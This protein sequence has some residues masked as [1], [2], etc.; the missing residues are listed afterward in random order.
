MIWAI[1]IFLG[2]PLWIIAL[3]L[4]ALVRNRSK[5]T[6]IPGSVH[7]KLKCS[8]GSVP[9]LGGDYARYTS[10]AHWI[11]DVLLVHKGTFLVQTL[12]VGVTGVA[13]KPEPIEVSSRIRRI[14]KPLVIRLT[15]DS[16][17]EIELVCMEADAARLVGPFGS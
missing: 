13:A 15:L 5:I 6:S 16:G 1:L 3:V 7:C 12:A 10:T 4:F 8:K 9:G 14:A 17:A 11:H 2:I